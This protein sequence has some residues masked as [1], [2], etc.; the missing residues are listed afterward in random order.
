MTI[1]TIIKQ[2]RHGALYALRLFVVSMFCVVVVGCS[3]QPPAPNDPRYAPVAP[4]VPSPSMH[5]VGSFMLVDQGL[6]YGKIKE[7]D[8]S[9]ILLLLFWKKKHP[10]KNPQKQKS[11]KMIPMTCRS[12][13]Y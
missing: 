8:V 9:A 13:H 1:P 4:I 12:L 2:L 3:A 7:Q 5:S 10:L 11:P 6:H